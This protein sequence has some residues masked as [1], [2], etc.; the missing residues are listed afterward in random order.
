MLID[1]VGDVLVTKYGDEQGFV[2]AYSANSQRVF[3]T[4][5]SLMK[6]VPIDLKSMLD[7][8]YKKL[9]TVEP[10]SYIA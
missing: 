2:S 4:I 1:D 8:T 6:V 9:V 10:D 7:A 3:K 5:V